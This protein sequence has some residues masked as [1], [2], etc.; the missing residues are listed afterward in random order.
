MSSLP[1]SPIGAANREQLRKLQSLHLTD[2]GNAEAFALLHG[3]AFR[4]D[5]DRNKWLV[6]NTKYWERT[7][8]RDVTMA[9]RQ[10]AI[11]RNTRKITK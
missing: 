2:A 7:A 4:Y 6:W 11:K 8:D 5:H 10:N 1:E 9:A 3:H